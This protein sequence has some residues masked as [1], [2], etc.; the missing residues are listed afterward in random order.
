MAQVRLLPAVI[1]TAGV[2]LALKAVSVAQAA[3]EPAAEAAAPA[4]EAKP[5]AAAG[6]ASPEMQCAAPSFAES[7]GLSATEVEVLQSLGQRRAALDA[8]EAEFATQSALLQAAEKRVN[9]RLAELK[10][11]EGVVGAMVAKLD[12]QQDARVTA[13]VVVYQKMKPKD[14]ADV[15]NGLDD[16]DLYA[17][18]SGMKQANLAE[19]MG[20]M[21]PDRARKLTSMMLKRDA[22]PADVAKAAPKPATG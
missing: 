19:I 1:A 18:A 13:M 5:A 9:E 4:V 21:Q 15:F 17:V 3:S 12:A 11:V 14:A 2:A 22:L 10:R 8:R 20:L 7:A 6:P 16:E